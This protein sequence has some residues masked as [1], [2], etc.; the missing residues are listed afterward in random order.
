MHILNSRFLDPLS[1]GIDAFTFHWSVYSNW[2]LPPVSL[3]AHTIKH[4]Q[5]CKAEGIVSRTL[6]EIGYM[7]ASVGLSWKFRFFSIVKDYKEYETPSI[8]F[9]R[10]S[11]DNSCIF[12]KQVYFKCISVAFIYQIL[13]YRYSLNADVAATVE[14]WTLP[15]YCWNVDFA[16]RCWF[17]DVPTMDMLSGC[18]L[19][20]LID[21]SLRATQKMQFVGERA[22]RTSHKLLNLSGRL[23]FFSIN[24]IHIQMTCLSSLN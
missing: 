15:L 22:K 23:I 9:I 14:M 12:W 20:W 10:G 7:L 19:I 16:S 21:I 6:V 11:A 5:L 24:H 17:A 4:I 13:N 2:L 8:Y 3:I 18:E 1:S